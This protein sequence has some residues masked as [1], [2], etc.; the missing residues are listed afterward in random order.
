MPEGAT[1]AELRTFAGDH[2]TPRVSS[3]VD[4][5]RSVVGINMHSKPAGGRCLVGDQHSHWATMVGTVGN[6]TGPGCITSCN[7]YCIVYGCLLA[8][9]NTSCV[10]TSCS[11]AAMLQMFMLR[12]TQL[13]PHTRHTSLEKTAH[14]VLTGHARHTATFKVLSTI[15]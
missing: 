7:M 3:L 10:D 12:A 9:F 13:L 2:P 14:A 4:Q 6:I 5:A 11:G 15:P 8:Y 1:W